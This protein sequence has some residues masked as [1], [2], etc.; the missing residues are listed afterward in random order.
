LR[1]SSCRPSS[2]ARTRPPALR[3]PGPLLR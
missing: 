3:V 1:S 2:A